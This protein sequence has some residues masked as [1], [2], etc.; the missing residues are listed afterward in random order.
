MA[1][2]MEQFLVPN[3]VVIGG[4]SG[5]STVLYHTLGLHAGTTYF[6]MNLLLLLLAYKVLGKSFVFRT[7]V[8]V[9]LIS[10]GSHFFSCFPP[11]TDDLLLS[12]VFG[13]FFY[14]IG[15]CIVFLKGATSGGS[16]IIG[17]L[18]QSVKPDVKIGAL[19][20][21]IDGAIVLL[22]AL[23]FGQ[24]DLCLFGGLSM[25]L[26]NSAVDIG[27]R[28]MNTTTVLLIVTNKGEEMAKALMSLY[29]RGCTIISARG[30]YTNEQRS[31]LVC[32]ARPREAAV[33]QSKINE[34]DSSAF[35]IFTEAGKIAGEGFQIYQ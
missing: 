22:S 27:I 9:A 4:I 18:I 28:K 16:D 1:M 35:V 14:G 32:A 24:W 15:L 29:E 19:L 26:C 21:I 13:G 20:V 30:A 31:V 6:L 25:I 17:R 3:K 10:A 23:V 12:A 33:Y 7:L 34:I 8:V 2:A 5:V 11:V